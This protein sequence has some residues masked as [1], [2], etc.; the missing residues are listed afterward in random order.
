MEKRREK[1]LYTIVKEHIATGSPVGSEI[2]VSKY[3][4]GVSSATVRNEMAELE[5]NGFI[6]QPHTSAGR[7][8]TEKAYAYYLDNLFHEKKIGANEES[9]ISRLMENRDESSFRQTAKAVAQ[10]SNQAVFWAFH[11]NN[12]YYTG[13][14]NLLAQPEFGQSDL[15]Y[16]ISAIIDRVDEIID[17]I[18]NEVK[19]GPQILFGSNN[20]FSP[21]CSTIISK[22]RLDDKVG[23][24]GIL[25]PIRMNYEKNLSL[26]K[27][28]DNNL[29]KKI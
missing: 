15:L 7:I 13:I 12:L 14:S 27:L 24:F 2:L 3:K 25:G 17:E 6:I 18:Y 23:L 10:F 8:P 28:I 11:Q 29:N 1:I 20:P 5:D 22:Y 26:V 16:D 4:L 19:F 21:V 9:I